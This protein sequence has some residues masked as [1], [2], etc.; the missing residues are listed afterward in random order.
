MKMLMPQLKIEKPATPGLPPNYENIFRS[1]QW[2][3]VFNYIMQT[4]MTPFELEDLVRSFYDE[5]NKNTKQ[6]DF[7]EMNQGSLL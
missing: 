2:V 4:N 1:P 5:R 3:R 6:M 7:E